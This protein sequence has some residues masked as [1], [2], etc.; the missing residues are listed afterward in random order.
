MYTVLTGV[1]DQ[2]LS[3]LP[4][5]SSSPD[6]SFCASGLESSRGRPWKVPGSEIR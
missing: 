3:P 5:E 2:A 1:G 6:S 4:S